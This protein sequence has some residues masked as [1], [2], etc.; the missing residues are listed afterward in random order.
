M[1]DIRTVPAYPGL[2][3]P[4]APTGCGGTVY[5]LVYCYDDEPDEAGRTEVRCIVA[6]EHDGIDDVPMSEARLA[7]DAP[8][9]TARVGLYLLARWI[10][11]R[12]GLDVSGGVTW[13]F[14][15]DA[16]ALGAVLELAD[17]TEESVIFHSVQ[18]GEA[19]PMRVLALVDCK[20]AADALAVVARVVAEETP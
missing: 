5:V 16:H 2:L 4:G 8:Q 18:L 12:K 19:D 14:N 13:Y 6:S 15:L 1:S 9:D 7:L 3:A 20:D 11:E 17:W 10:A